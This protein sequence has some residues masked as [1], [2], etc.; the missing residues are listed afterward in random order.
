MIDWS[1]HKLETMVEFFEFCRNLEYGWIDHAGRKHYEPNGSPEY[2]LQTPAEVLQNRIGICWDQ[3]ELQR[4]WFTEHNYPVETYL[5]YYE[6]RED[7]WPSHSI[8]IYQEGNDF[9]WF[10]PM[11]NQTAIYYC[12]IHRA[13]SREEIWDKLATKFMRNGQLM[14][15]LPQE[16]VAEK[17]AIYR[18]EK[19]TYGIDD[20]EFYRHCL[21]GEKVR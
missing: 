5:V 15:M 4:A 2:F 13:K 14:G 21:R 20:Q 1:K 18:Y 7:C 6:A 12:G 16:F 11:F 9:C 10:E 19:P 3:T 17:L 8:L